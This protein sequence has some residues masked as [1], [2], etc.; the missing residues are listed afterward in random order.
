MYGERSVDGGW[1]DYDRWA[2]RSGREDISYK[3]SYKEE[4]EKE[5]LEQY[6]S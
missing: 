1:P 5:R 4:R 2:Y 3:I 6:N